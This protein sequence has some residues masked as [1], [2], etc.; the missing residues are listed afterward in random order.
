MRSREGK[1]A[2]RFL[3]GCALVLVLALDAR[4]AGAD[5]LE[6]GF[7]NPPASARP[8]TWWHWMNGNITREGISADLEA[9]RRVGI[10]GA[11]IFNVDCG[12]P[13]GPVRFLSPEWR[14]LM[15][16]TAQEANRLG[17]KLCLHNCAGWS[18]SGGPWNTPEHAMARVTISETTVTG[19]SHFSAI[20]P[21][22]STQLGYYRD[23]AV[24]AFPGPTGRVAHDRSDSVKP[25]RIDNVAAK[26]GFNGNAILSSPPGAYPKNGRVVSRS[27]VLDLS[28]QL[29]GDGRLEWD[30]PAGKWTVLRFGY[31]PTGRK[32]HPAPAE[33]TG[34]ECDKFSREAL[35]A[36]WAGFMQKVLEDLGPLAGQGRTLDNVLI[37][38]YEVGGQNWTPQ[39]RAEF[40][41]RR[42]YDPLLYL[43][44]LS[45]RVVDSPEV[46]ERF[47][48]DV[49]RTIA[50]LFAE[51]YYGHFQALCHQHGLQASIEPY[52]GPFDSLQCGQKADIPMGEFWVGSAP[53]AS[54]KLASSIGHICGQ[55]I[56]GAES[57]TAAPGPRHGR[58][59]DD[60][61]ALKALGDLV[62]CQGVNRLIFHRYA[63]QPWTN[64]WP[65]MT[66]GQWGTHF[67]RTCTWWEQGRAWIQ[68]LARCQ[69]LL[70]QGRCV[71]DIACFCGQSAPS[72]LRVGDPPVPAGY[73]YDAV[74]ADVL[75]HGAGVKA[76]RLVLA[77]GASYAVLVLPPSDPAMTPDLLRRLAR[78][79]AEGLSVVGPPPPASPSLEDCP[80][81]D[82]EVK[83]LAS[84]VWGNCDGK[85]VTAHPFGQGSVHW[86]EPL[87]KVLLGLD[88]QPDFTFS[89][90]A[91]TSLAFI[92]R[93]DGSADIYFVSN[94]RATGASIE[95]GFRVQGRAPEL[96]DAQTGR[97]QPA[98][99]WREEDGRT[100]VPLS[101]APAGSVFVVFRPK[102]VS[103]HL[104]SVQR[105]IAETG[106]DGAHH[107][108][109]R[110]LR[111]EYGA[112][113][114]SGESWVD[115]TTNM[116]ALL[117]AGKRRIPASNEMA[118]EDPAPMMLKELRV[119]YRTRAREEK[120]VV[121]EGKTLVLPAEA[122][123]LR[124]R[125][126]Q[127]RLDHD[128]TKDLTAKLA[129]L[130]K[131]GRIQER[132]DNQLAGGDPAPDIPK[133]LRIQYAT[134]GVAVR[135]TVAEGDMLTLPEPGPGNPYPRQYSL[136]VG[137]DGVT[138][139]AAREPADF[140]CLW[141]SGRQSGVQC[142]SV[143]A[144]LELTGPWEVRFPPGWG[145]PALIALD[146]LK[147]WTENRDPGVKYF[148][149]TAGYSKVFEL[150]AELLEGKRELW[151]DLGAVKNIAEVW[152]N[153]TSLGILWKPP[154]E[155]NVSAAVRPGTNTLE[156]KVTNL[157]PN[158]LIGDEHLPPDCQWKGR[159]LRAWP[160]W[161]TQGKPSPTGRLT[162]TTWH[163]WTR[164]DALLPSG[165]LGP[166][167]LRPAEVL[168]VR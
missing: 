92:H 25:L 3:S 150:P 137:Q 136:A 77:S 142:R 12:I 71:A 140:V 66:M 84:Q 37:D 78:F 94:Q 157:W 56:I 114:D 99:V 105:R 44:T 24:L 101:L 82:V 117:A 50:D 86:G 108:D 52:T 79:V 148:S 17:L 30:V 124:A 59:L 20:L 22:P 90:N 147:S 146:P 167:T 132:V 2:R 135:T 163:H 93:Q 89:N 62:F 61:Y 9:M 63:M 149:G 161:L 49:R 133:E 113:A 42:G 118:G 164:D 110:I 18:S 88:Q 165:L 103:D 64:R 126:G 160:E 45:G 6:A 51:N 58:W 123:V 53:D 21:R 47:L 153:G 23:I 141:S 81:C 46:S 36:H 73:D 65:G 143:P 158:R 155:L 106:Q 138:R 120:A 5:S 168:V 69:F 144:T 48:W 38:S 15:L 39:F 111:A 154:F 139:L 130:V 4:P 116:Q 74:D 40:R 14:A 35:D 85:T 55:P 91:D 1:V 159:Q 96:W 127:F 11:E 156:V 19:P 29:G 10:G 104:V 28:S 54:V 68:Y 152:L 162:F 109:L 128:L 60:P 27:Q 166:V 121:Q 102:P 134:N 131:D 72:E 87:A 100:L 32:N 83:Q 151:L 119:A 33:A 80:R 95:C 34:L 97:I 41:K 75:L 129:A 43:P 31:T 8:Q 16:W 57:F 67:D 125:Y 98:P 145:A 112:F 13:A 115:V 26:G 70:Q 7:Q 122:H 76:G 107:A